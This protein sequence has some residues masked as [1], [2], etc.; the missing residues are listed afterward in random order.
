VARAAR[1]GRLK[2]IAPFSAPRVPSSQVSS[3]TPHRVESHAC[4]L[5]PQAIAIGHHPEVI[6]AGRRINDRMGA[7]VAETLVKL[8]LQSGIGVCNSRV[9]VLGL[10][11]KENC[12]D[13]RNTRVVDII[14]ALREYSLRVEVQDPW[15]E[16][17]EAKHEYRLDCLAALPDPGTYDAFGAALGR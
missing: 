2:P 10:A 9:L 7:H 5:T 12:P 8:M 1:G 14:D 15:V 16:R 13:L 4:Y 17:A 11:F 6:L 3:G